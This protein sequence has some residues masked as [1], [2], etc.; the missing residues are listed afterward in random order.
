VN[1]VPAYASYKNEPGAPGHGAGPAVWMETADHRQTMSCGSS[2]DAQKHRAKQNMHIKQGQWGKAIEMD[3]K[4]IQGKFG[5]KY[6]PGLKQLID[7]AHS[8]GLIDE[9]EAARLKKKCK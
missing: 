9:K 5:N 6:N 2:T 1:H 8:A 4:D 3:I 7:R